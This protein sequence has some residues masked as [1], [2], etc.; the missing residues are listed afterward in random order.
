MK[1]RITYTDRNNNEHV[2]VVDSKGFRD[3]MMFLMWTKGEIKKIEK[4]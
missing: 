4:I 3:L 2:T 1:E